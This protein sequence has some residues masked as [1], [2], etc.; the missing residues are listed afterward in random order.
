[1]IPEHCTASPASRD[2]TLTSIAEGTGQRAIESAALVWPADLPRL[3]VARQQIDRSCGIDLSFV[4]A[5]GRTYTFE[6]F[7]SL[8]G[9]AAAENA[10]SRG[11]RAV[12]DAHVSAWHQLWQ[13]DIRVRGDPRLQT[14]VHAMLFY[15]LESA[16]GREEL[17]IPPM[18]LSTAGYYGHIFWDADT[19][20]FPVLMVLHPE[21]A[22]ALVMFRYRTLDAARRNAKQNGRRGAMFPWE[23]GP[24]GAEATP[25]FAYQN[26]LSE[27]HVD[28]DIAL[29]AWQYYVAT[30]DHGWLEHYGDPILHDTADF[31]TSRVTYNQ[32]KDRFEIH[33]VVSVDESKIGVADDPYTNAAAKKNLDLAIQAARVLGRI[34]NPKWGAIS[35]KLYLPRQDLVLI[36]YPLGFPLSLADKRAIVDNALNQATG[37]QAGV[38]MEVEFQ[39]IPAVELGN[40]SVLQR[41]LEKTYAG[42]LRP[43]FDVPAE[44][45]SNNNISFLTGA[46]AFLQQF[47]FG[48]TGLRFS[49]EAGLS[50]KFTPLLPGNIKQLVVAGISI[51]G[52]RTTVTIPN[53]N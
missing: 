49:P 35:R 28:A 33:G 41:L 4:A 24:D 20:M 14:I 16:T 53:R 40:R 17:S 18:G 52:R 34:P 10:R 43:P 13:Q 46:G 32:A 2:V 7:V 36:D 47:I 15:L 3:T 45:P 21:M 6:K 25:R 31:W 5:G 44:T 26:A 9:A 27:N 30:G 29:E 39:P 22:K 12:R 50:R 38:M 19:F 37:R 48:Y 1:M 8:V 51:R 23:A 42:Y 11:Y